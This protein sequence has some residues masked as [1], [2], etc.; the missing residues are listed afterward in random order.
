MGAD[1]AVEGGDG[2]LDA[3]EAG[4]GAGQLEAGGL[5]A[6]EIALLDGA[7]GIEQA[8]L[9]AFA[10]SALRGVGDSKELFVAGE[11]GEAFGLGDEGAVVPLGKGDDR[12]VAGSGEKFWLLLLDLLKLFD[13]ASAVAGPEVDEGLVAKDGAGGGV[14]LLRD[15]DFGAGFLKAAE[16]EERG[17][18]PV[19]G[20]FVAG[21]EGWDPLESTCRHASLSIL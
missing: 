20:F 10:E 9:A 1:G 18:V 4:A 17:G 3:A 7:H 12:Q 2:V 5:A 15:V 19:V 21:I 14:E 8:V 11:G 16:G 6:V 13:G